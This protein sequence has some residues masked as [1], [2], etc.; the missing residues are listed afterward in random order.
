MKNSIGNLV[1]LC[2]L[3]VVSSNTSAQLAVIDGAAA[4]NWITQLKQAK[5]QYDEV[6]NQYKQLQK[7]HKAISGIRNMGQLLNNPMLTQ[8]MP[9]EYLPVL[10][11]IRNGASGNGNA[12]TR[13][14]ATILA[15]IQ[16]K[17]CKETTSNDNEKK[18]CEERWRAIASQ[19][20]L[21]QNAYKDAGRTIDSLNLFMG[22]IQES[23]DP[24]AIQDLQAR[25]A[26]EQIRIQN[27]QQKLNALTI[28]KNLEEEAKNANAQQSRVG[29]LSKGAGGMLTR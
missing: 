21:S 18:A 1:G 15:D 16:A 4:A 12:M 3:L 9:Q 29:A 11:A 23:E 17:N 22:K 20:M 7:T 24:K 5:A 13:Q 28:L 10:E 14:M 27:E 26:I 8:N 2:A 25:L 6:V 19:R